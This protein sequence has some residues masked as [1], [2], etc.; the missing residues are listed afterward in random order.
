MN[1]AAGELEEANNLLLSQLPELV[2]HQKQRPIPHLVLKLALRGRPRRA[3]WLLVPHTAITPFGRWDILRWMG[4]NAI[5][6]K[7]RLTVDKRDK[8]LVA[9]SS[10]SF[11]RSCIFCI[12][13][14]SREIKRAKGE[15]LCTSV[16]CRFPRWL[17]GGFAEQNIL[18]AYIFLT[19]VT[20]LIAFDVINTNL[21][22]G[23]FFWNP[24]IGV[25]V[26]MLSMYYQFVASWVIVSIPWC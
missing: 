7:Q 25:F 18:H 14:T 19:L 24:G 1:E 4:E 21:G 8:R 10:S 23:V 22:I 6:E 5:E 26:Y 16:V 13:A 2:E 11:T 20:I 3:P 17:R 9:S 15:N 12:A